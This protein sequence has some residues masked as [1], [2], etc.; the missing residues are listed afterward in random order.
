MHSSTSASH[1]KRPIADIICDNF[2]FA[3]AQY[4]YLLDQIGGQ[5]GL[6]RT[7]EN[8]VLRLVPF[9]DWTSGFFGG[10]LWY[11]LEGTS[12]DKWRA[13]ARTFTAMVE[14]AKR[15]R[16]T[17]DVGFVLYCSFGNGWR[18]TRDAHYRDVL[19]EG[20]K[21]LGTRFSPV[22]GCIKSWDGV[23]QWSFPVII[24]NLM[25][26]ELLVWAARASEDRS[27][28]NIAVAHASTTLRHHFR[29]DASS[30][31]VIDYDADTGLVRGRQTHQGMADRSAWARGQAWGV[32][33][34]TMMYRETRLPA[35]LEQASR[36]AEFITNH[37][38]LP[39]DKIPYWDFDA[40]PSPDTSRDVSAAAVICSAL[41]ELSEFVPA[42]AAL[43]YRDL[44]HQQLRALSSE[45][46]RAP[47]GGNG[48]FLLMHATGH[49]PR[50]S[51]V[52]APLAYAD[53]YFLEALL[54]ARRQLDDATPGAAE[55]LG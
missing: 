11:L 27:L 16:G 46:Y 23:E 4:A 44:A 10:S 40:P 31:H 13:V 36:I 47:V 54:R 29:P 6:P 7:W 25:N 20:A 15:N 39:E 1:S 53:Y 14:P 22:V 50:S 21:S 51:E 26:L 18:L 52:D 42:A 28:Y 2:D 37:P 8:G 3:A 32:Y 5:P 45:R 41:L 43:R 55:A 24:D 49:H 17:H 48:G 34:Y 30:Y 9:S 33:G 12:D 19:L 38:R 35:Y